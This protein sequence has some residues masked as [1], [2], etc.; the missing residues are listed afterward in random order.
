M[1]IYI[2]PRP[3]SDRVGKLSP[4]P[5]P[6]RLLIPWTR[7]MRVGYSWR[8]KSAGIIVIPNFILL[9]DG[10][11]PIS[12]LNWG[13]KSDRSQPLPAVPIS[14]LFVCLCAGYEAQ[15][16]NS[17]ENIDWSVNS[18]WTIL[19]FF[20]CSQVTNILSSKERKEK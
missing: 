15:T 20:I 11:F 12:F 17:L 14:V 19:V 10:M 8:P 5:A 16:Q 3:E 2:P 9:I 4:G 1:G 6:P 13:L 7:P 18:T